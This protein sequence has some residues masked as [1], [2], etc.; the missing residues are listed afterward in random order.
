MSQLNFFMTQEE[1]RNEVEE[2]INSSLFVLFNGSFFNF[3]IPTPMTNSKEIGES[4]RI[5]IWIK[6]EITQP[7][8]SK[9]G[10]GNYSD[11]FLFDY[12]YDPIIEFDIEN[13][14][15][16][17]ISPSRIFYKAGWIKDKEIRDFHTKATSKLVRTIKKKLKTWDKIKPFYISKNTMN[18]LDNGFEIELGNGGMRLN[19]QTINGT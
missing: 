15:G 9:K 18:L 10:A 12:Y 2:L 17:L 1:I 4:K 13:I 7:K 19:K 8:C 6:N 3:E 5:I 14:V 11:K 16:N